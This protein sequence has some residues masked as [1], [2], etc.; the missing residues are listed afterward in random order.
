M[1]VRTPAG[2]IAAPATSGL[3]GVVDAVADTVRAACE[4]R[5]VPGVAVGIVF[6]GVEH[7]AVFGVTSVE[8]PLDVDVDTLFQ[9]GSITKTFTATAVMRLVESGVLDLERPIATYLPELRLSDAQATTEVTLR[10]LLTHTAGWEGD[11][12]S[13]PGAGDDALARYVAGMAELPQLTPPGQT[14]SYCNSGFCLAGR[15][16]EVATGKTYEMALRELVLEPLDMRHSFFLPAEVMTHRF[17]VGHYIRED[18]VV[19]ARPWPIPR[20]SH[21]AGGITTSLKD[22]SRYARFHLG[23]GLAPDG[24]RL[25]TSETLALMQSPH[26]TAGHMA[27]SVGLAWL[28]RN[29]QGVDVVEHGGG[30]NGQTSTLELVP[31]RDF[32]VA[33]LTNADRGGELC[34]EVTDGVFKHLLGLEQLEPRVLDLPPEQLAVYVGQYET[35]L[36]T[37]DLTLKDTGLVAQVTPKGGFPTKD[38]PPWPASPPTRV[39]FFA[40][41]RILALDPPWTGS[42]AE[43]LRH[44]DGRIAWLRWGGRIAARHERQE[45]VS[46]KL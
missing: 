18:G 9:I 36:N 30:T 43:F 11:D 5:K 34:G 44:A 28:L 41:D 12:F 26:A 32:A 19:V 1:E 33:V 7:T 16:I 46:V 14:W 17:A 37:I 10:H 38:S 6:A 35:R 45:V 29:M 27:E 23:D 22:L 21:A 4:R 24:T 15:V 8:H 20:A 31:E 3:E 25:L 2:D 40:E 39:A 13:D 42:R